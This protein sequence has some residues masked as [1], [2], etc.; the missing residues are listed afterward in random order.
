MALSKHLIVPRPNPQ[1]AMVAREHDR[2]VKRTLYLLLAGLAACRKS[3]LEMLRWDWS[4]SR[5][6]GSRFQRR[7]SALAA[8]GRVRVKGCGRRRGYLRKNAS[9]RYSR[10]R[11]AE[12]ADSAPEDWTCSQ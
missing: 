10:R 3:E 8:P 1:P 2:R 4:I 12:S 11:D 6:T 9:T 5:G 7:K